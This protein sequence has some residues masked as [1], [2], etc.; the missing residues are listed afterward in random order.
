MGLKNSMVKRL[1]CQNL[2][3][4]YSNISKTNFTRIKK[5]IAKKRL[6]CKLVRCKIRISVEILFF[7]NLA[8]LC[9]YGIKTI[10][11][12]EICNNEKDLLL[13]AL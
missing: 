12:L 3:K 2:L 10:E 5:V 8:V 6:E 11:S 1:V 9:N 7:E 4:N 13:Q